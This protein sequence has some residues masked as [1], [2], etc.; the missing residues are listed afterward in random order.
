MTA[1]IYNVVDDTRLALTPE[2][3][4]KGDFTLQDTISGR[5]PATVFKLVLSVII[6]THT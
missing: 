4:Q 5:C 2:I 6:H 1:Y 3:S